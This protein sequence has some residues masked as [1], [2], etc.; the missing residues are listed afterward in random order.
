MWGA[1]LSLLRYAIVGIYAF[2]RVRSDVL[3]MWCG[4][5][6]CVYALYVQRAFLLSRRVLRAAWVGF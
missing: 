4:V 3:V 1:V 5:V 2:C 6:W